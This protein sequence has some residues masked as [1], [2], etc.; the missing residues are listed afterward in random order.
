MCNCDNIEATI[1]PQFDPTA[2][3]NAGDLVYYGGK[4]YEC[5][6]DDTAGNWNP[7]R[8]V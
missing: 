3:Y 1:A 6:L 5:L 2:A 7:S 4:L 8:F